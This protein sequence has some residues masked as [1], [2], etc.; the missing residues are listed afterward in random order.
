MKTIQVGDTILL[1]THKESGQYNTGVVIEISEHHTGN[2]LVR[3]KQPSFK[4]RCDAADLRVLTK[5]D[6]P[7]YFI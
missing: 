1:N 5:E 4:L 7:E 3:Y 6:N 2:I